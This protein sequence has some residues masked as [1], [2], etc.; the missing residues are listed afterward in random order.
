MSN[1]SRIK[2]NTENTGKGYKYRKFIKNIRKDMKLSRLLAIGV[3]VAAPATAL[4]L[5][6]LWM[7]DV[8]ISPDGRTIAFQYKGD[9]WT[10]PVEGGNAE[11]LTAHK[12]WLGLTAAVL[13]VG[14]C[15][16]SLLSY[17][18]F[19]SRQMSVN[20]NVDIERIGHALLSTDKWGYLLPFEAI[21]ILLLACII[22]GVVIARKR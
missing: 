14:V 10:V 12:K 9:I 16:Y 18:A 21:S 8:K 3:F 4:A 15:G 1:L 20:L 2:K 17:G 19:L 5:T 6:P 7:R 11:R 22:G 13:G